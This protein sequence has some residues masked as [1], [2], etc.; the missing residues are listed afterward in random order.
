MLDFKKFN[1]GACEDIR[2][3]AVE[4]R[5]KM[6][7]DEYGDNHSP[8]ERE[9]CNYDRPSDER[10]LKLLSGVLYLISNNL[11]DFDKATWIGL[12]NHM[13]M[14]KVVTSFFPDK[15]EALDEVH[16]QPRD[17]PVPL[18]SF[19]DLPELTWMAILFVAQQVEDTP[20]DCIEDALR[21]VLSHL[22]KLHPE[23]V[24][25]DDPK[26]ED[27][28]TL[29]S[30]TK[31]GNTF[32]LIWKMQFSEGGAIFLGNSTEVTVAF[33]DGNKFERLSA[34]PM[35]HISDAWGVNFAEVL[36]VKSFAAV[37]AHLSK[38]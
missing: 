27:S 34:E 28:W 4:V 23:C 21:V 10:V 26:I 14:Y 17:L 19:N 35:L 38:V 12:V 13:E 37:S 20:Y 2:A 15:M 22:T 1:S 25:K 16:G 18:A 11:P 7:L 33:S 6:R 30:L 8:L 29:T 24:F 9:Y 31:K 5:H 36:T 3:E 32:D